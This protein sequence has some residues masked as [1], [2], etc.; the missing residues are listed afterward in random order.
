V[1]YIFPAPSDDDS[2]KPAVQFETFPLQL[3]SSYNSTLQPLG[4]LLGPTVT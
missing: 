4:Q 1:K 3:G 2:L